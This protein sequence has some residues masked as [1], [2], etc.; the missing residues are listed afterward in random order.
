LAQRDPAEKHQSGEKAGSVKSETPSQNLEDIAEPARWIESCTFKFKGGEVIWFN[1]MGANDVRFMPILDSEKEIF[2][3]CMRMIP[4]D[5]DKA[6]IYKIWL[7][8]RITEIK[9]L[10]NRTR[11][12]ADAI[13][14]MGGGIFN[15]SGAI[16]SHSQCAYLK[17]RIQFESKGP[18]LNKDDKIKAVSK[19]YLGMVGMD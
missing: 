4:L 12:E 5:P 3:E 16:Y 19:P 2:D 10:M 17:V 14:T 1:D 6:K 11:K 13:L 7:H 8:D 9:S 15:S 18:A